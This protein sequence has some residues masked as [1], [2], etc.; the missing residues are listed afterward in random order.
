MSDTF[1]TRAQC[2]Q[3]AINNLLYLI[4][5][6]T[7]EE[8]RNDF[9]LSVEGKTGSGQSGNRRSAKALDSPLD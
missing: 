4:E 6:S 1:Q 2:V 9:R 5:T 7:S 8:M 3:Q